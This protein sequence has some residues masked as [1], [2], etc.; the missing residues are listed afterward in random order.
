[1]NI[2]YYLLLLIY[3]IIIIGKNSYLLQITYYL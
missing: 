1:M 3:F 2:F